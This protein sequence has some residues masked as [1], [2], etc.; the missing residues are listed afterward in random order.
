MTTATAL[1]KEIN[2]QMERAKRADGSEYYRLKDGRPDWMQDVIHTAHGDMMPNDYRY[3]AIAEA[4]D[5]IEDLDDIDDDDARAEFADNVDVYNHDLIEWLG[6][7][8]SRQGYCDEASAE[9]GVT[10]SDSDDIM[11]RIMRGQYMERDEIW[12]LL[13][14]ALQDHADDAESEAA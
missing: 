13:V 5:V 2:V 11:A 12:S 9:Y 6:S 10:D 1:A 3:R 8:G 4:L 14:Q 7:H